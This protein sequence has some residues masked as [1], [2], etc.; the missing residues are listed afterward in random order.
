VLEGFVGLDRV[1]DGT[2]APTPRATCELQG[3]VYDAKHA[4]ARLAREVWDDPRWRTAGQ[5]GRRSSRARSTRTSGSRARLLR[6]GARRPEAQGRFA[7][8]E[9]RPPAVERDRRRGEGRP[10]ASST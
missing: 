2:L 9:H 5:R 6:A 3:Y 10:A 1:R 8:L 7:D 4:G